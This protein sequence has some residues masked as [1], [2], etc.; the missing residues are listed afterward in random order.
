MSLSDL[1]GHIPTIEELTERLEAVI[2]ERDS[3]NTTL[4]VLQEKITNGILVERSKGKDDQVIVRGDLMYFVGDDGRRKPVTVNVA[5]DGVVIGMDGCAYMAADLVHSEDT[6][7]EVMHDSETA[8][9]DELIS[10]LS[11][12]RDRQNAQTE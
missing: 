1:F 3:L 9:I 6:V 2:R 5:S 10:R 7:E 11:A 4:G 8:S 12:I